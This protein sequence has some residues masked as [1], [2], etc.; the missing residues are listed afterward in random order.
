MF[1]L[2]LVV[3]GVIALVVVKVVRPHKAALQAAAQSVG[4]NTTDWTQQ[5][6]NGIS[7]GINQAAG[8]VTNTMGGRRMLH[9]R[10]IQQRLPFT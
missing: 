2:F 9:L 3:C 6:S 10:D 4:L 7:N 5:I 1:L 8:A